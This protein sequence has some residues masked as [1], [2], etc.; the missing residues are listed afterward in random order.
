MNSLA[1]IFVYM[2]V[3][4][5]VLLP[6]SAILHMITTGL[7]AFSCPYTHACTLYLLLFDSFDCMVSTTSLFINLL[8]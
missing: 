6:N 7:A 2:D 8:P 4:Q 5:K 1:T 3:L